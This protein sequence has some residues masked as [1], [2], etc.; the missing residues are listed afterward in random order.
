MRHERSL[1]FYVTDLKL[2]LCYKLYKSQV[3]FKLRFMKISRDF[4]SSRTLYPEISR[5]TSYPRLPRSHSETFVAQW[6][7]SD[8]EPIL[9]LMHLQLRFYDWP[10]DRRLLAKIERHLGHCRGSPCMRARRIRSGT[11]KTTAGKR[12]KAAGTRSGSKWFRKRCPPTRKSARAI[13][14][15]KLASQIMPAVFVRC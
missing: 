3:W 8:K 14:E 10:G 4:H 7:Q 9:G 15:L 5:E 6:S 13:S 2:Y 11:T 1:C 12:E